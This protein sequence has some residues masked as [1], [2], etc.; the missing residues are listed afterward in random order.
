MVDRGECGADF[1]L[2]IEHPPADRVRRQVFN[3]RGVR[4]RFAPAAP[5]RIAIGAFKLS[6]RLRQAA[7]DAARCRN[8][9]SIMRERDRDAEREIPGLG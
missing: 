3:P 6:G 4:R 2:R 8:G 9:A 5:V 7:D 1:I